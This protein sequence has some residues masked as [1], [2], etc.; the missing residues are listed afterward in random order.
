MSKEQKK[1]QSYFF[2]LKIEFF[3]IESHV[4]RHGNVY[5]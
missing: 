4:G 3:L 1:I 2:Q 5:W